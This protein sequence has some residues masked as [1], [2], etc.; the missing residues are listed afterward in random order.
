MGSGQRT[1][2]GRHLQLPI[3]NGAHQHRHDTNRT[4][5]PAPPPRSQRGGLQKLAAHNTVSLQLV[6]PV[7]VQVAPTG[8]TGE[9]TPHSALRGRI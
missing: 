6:T 4:T 1:S 3:P 2:R 8:P 5:Q 7:L 9:L